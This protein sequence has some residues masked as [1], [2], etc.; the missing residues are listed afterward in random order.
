[1]TEQA[2][3]RWPERIRANRHVQALVADDTFA[4]LADRVERMLSHGRRICL[5]VRGFNLGGE[6]DVHAGL[7]LGRVE[8]TAPEGRCV[9]EV[10]LEPGLRTAF[11]F[12]SPTGVN[13]VTER[14]AW[15][16]FYAAGGR[17]N[18]TKLTL[19][20]GLANDGPAN[21]DRITIDRWNSDGARTQTVVVFDPRPDHQS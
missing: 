2:P 7:T 10:V 20:G 17:Y 3:G 1:M 18:F 13:A 6:M 19:C 16:R 14:E 21:D 9:F 4:P 8:R 15:A 11:G 5:A 12:A